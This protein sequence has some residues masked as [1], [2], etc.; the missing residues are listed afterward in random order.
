MTS[1]S[2]RAASTFRPCA[3]RK[4]GQTPS[5]GAWNDL[6][7]EY[8]REAPD[9]RHSA[10]EPPHAR[11]IVDLAIAVVVGDHDDG[12]SAS[13]PSDVARRLRADRIDGIDLLIVGFP[14]GLLLATDVVVTAS[15]LYEM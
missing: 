11:R 2:A 5:T 7:S 6:V 9:R 13:I 14:W 4:R 1:Y 8:A 15:D 10:V 3:W 12:R